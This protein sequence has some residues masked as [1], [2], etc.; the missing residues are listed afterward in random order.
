MVKIHTTNLAVLVL[1]LGGGL[2]LSANA[3]QTLGAPVADERGWLPPGGS[4]QV[5]THQGIRFA[6]GGIGLSGRDELRALSPQFNLQ[7]MFAMQ[8]SGNYLAGAQVRILN[9]HGVVVLDATS[10]GPYFLAQLPP[11]NYIVEVSTLGQTQRQTA[12]IGQQQSRLNF[13]WR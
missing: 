12:R 3:Q 6:S 2:S 5:Q 4:I 8:G 10:E 13:F 7:L 11:G 9:S 1:L